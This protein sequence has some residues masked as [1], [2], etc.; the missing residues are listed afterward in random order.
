MKEI[1]RHAAAVLVLRPFEDTYQVLLLNKPR[2]RDA[3]QIPQGGIEKGEFVEE[4]GLRE[5]YEEAGVDDV[6]VI[7]Q[8]RRVYQYDFPQSYRRFRPDNVK[9]QRIEFVLAL[10]KK[11]CHV[12]VDD[13][14]IVGHVWCGFD[15]L[16]QYLK[17]KRYLKFVRTLVDEACK[18]IDN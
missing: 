14:E 17:R 18:I 9:G 1:Y 4:A 15:D 7:G 16:D 10:A 2:K 12:V 13:H 3:W 11:D 5:L 6:K 8:S